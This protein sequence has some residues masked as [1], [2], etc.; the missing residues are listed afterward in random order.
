MS[1]NYQLLQRVPSDRKVVHLRLEETRPLCIMA[2]STRIFFKIL[3]VSFGWYFWQNKKFNVGTGAPYQRQDVYQDKTNIGNLK[4]N[5]GCPPLT[6]SRTSADC[7][8]NS[9]GPSM[10]YI[11]LG[12]YHTGGFNAMDA[13]QCRC[14]RLLSQ[15]YV[16]MHTMFGNESNMA[17]V[18]GRKSPL[19][20]DPFSTLT[21]RV[22]LFRGWWIKAHICFELSA[23]C[24]QNPAV[25]SLKFNRM[26]WS[27]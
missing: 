5:R 27:W 1:I 22:S 16:A 6:A 11:P 9:L 14:T 21:F 2:R 4:V 18:A 10:Q 8:E 3:C 7:F 15:S 12:V 19:S 17:V 13:S 23:M 26:M 25:T 20:H 24:M